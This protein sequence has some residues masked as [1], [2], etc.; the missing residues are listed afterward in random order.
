MCNHKVNFWYEKLG[1]II[2][3]LFTNISRMQRI[4]T[5]VKSTNYIYIYST[6]YWKLII[7]YKFKILRFRR[8]N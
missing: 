2:F 3:I 6:L 5:R 8:R 4:E 1:N 7:Y